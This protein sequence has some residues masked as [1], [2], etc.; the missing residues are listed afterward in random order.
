MAQP[1]PTSDP[2]SDPARVPPRVAWAA[3]FVALVALAAAARL[4]WMIDRHAVNVP[5]WDQFTLYQAFADGAGPWELFRWQHGPHR[6]GVAFWLTWAIATAS[7]WNTRAEAFAVGLAV[8]GATALALGLRRRLFG[9]LHA[10]DAAIPLLI[11]TPAQY[12]IFLHTPNLSHGAAPLFGLLLLCAAF[13]LESGGRRYAALVALDFAL[14]HTGFGIFVGALTPP[15]LILLALHE[16]RAAAASA[17][18]LPDGRLPALAV[19]LSLTSVGVFLWGLERDPGLAAA[20]GARPPAGAYAAYVGLMFANVLG[21]KAVTGLHAWIGGAVALV[22]LGVAAE[23]ASRLLRGHPRPAPCCAILTL[24]SFT[25]LYAAVTAFGRLPLGVSGAQA[26]RYV[27]LMVP[28]FLGL[29]L[30]LQEVGRPRVRRA[31]LGLAVAAIAWATIPMRAPEARFVEHLSRGKRA[32]VEAYLATGSVAT[33][34]AR[35]GLRLFPH[36][37]PEFPRILAHMREQGLGFFADPPPDG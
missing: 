14:L 4:L 22:A 6:Q 19:A 25:L 37:A 36:D 26:T 35:S 29:Y 34:D 21:L 33:A 30:R 10:G 9:A 18:P 23:Q 20:S 8:C 31:L 17:A 28:A 1:E 24:L 27:P 12:G 3:C 2:A 13:T 32:W 15:L 7:G 16:R 11:L 5:F